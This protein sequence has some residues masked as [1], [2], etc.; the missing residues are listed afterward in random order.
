MR[1]TSEPWH[2]GVARLVGRAA[3]DI[4]PLRRH[5]EFRLLWIGQSASWFGRM[6]ALVAVPFQ[7]YR[8]THST[9][10]VGVLELLA[11]FPLV[12]LG[13]VGGAFADA[14][15]RRRIVLLSELGFVAA[16]ALLLMNSLLPHPY[17]VAI[18][19]LE[20]TAG[21][22]YALQRPSL[23]ALLPRLVERDEITAAATLSS[24]RSTVAMIAGPALAGIVIATMGLPAAYLFYVI[25]LVISAVALVAM[26]AVPPATMAEPASLKR[27]KEGIDYARSR[28]DLMGT[29][30]VDFVAMFFG[31][32]VALFPAVADRL[33]GP[34]VLGALTAGPA[35]GSFAVSLVS[36]WTSSVHRH[37]RAIVLAASAW[38]LAIVAFGFAPNVATA[39]LFLALAGGADMVSGIF[40][41]TIWNQT[42]PDHLR[43][44]L[45]GIE[46]I[47]FTSGP[48]LGNFEAGAVASAFGLRFSIVSGGALCVVGA[49]SCA[50]LLPGFWSYDNRRTG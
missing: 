12:T 15:D 26:Q 43:G 11:F 29:Y 19:A 5:R 8:M 36:G 22:L 4:G 49:A 48:S 18:Y 41:S 31:M 14:H 13:L 2:A 24:L 21:A 9:L 16:A 35:I 28:P 38:G 50:L 46:L 23:D 47:S 20:I 3:V 37:G 32:P 45:A 33:G 34:A 30:L 6:S 44:R 39:L 25:F 40:R 7:I 42:I 17:L 1:E 10:A 27:I